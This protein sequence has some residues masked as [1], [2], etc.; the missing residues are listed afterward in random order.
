[1]F[2]LLNQPC[3]KEISNQFVNLLKVLRFMAFNKFGI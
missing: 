2:L 1:M 3:Y